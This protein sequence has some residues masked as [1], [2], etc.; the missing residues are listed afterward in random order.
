[1]WDK[2][3]TISP[4]I[5]AL[6]GGVVTAAAIID[7]REHR[8]P[9]YLTI[10]A[11]LI[12]FLYSFLNGWIGPASS[13]AGLLV[14]FSLLILPWI[15]GG[16]GMGDVKLLAAL[17]AWMG[18][19]YIL[20]IFAG[21]AMFASLMAIGIMIYTAITEGVGASKERYLATAGGTAN[22]S[23]V[24]KKMKRVVPFAVPIAMSS[25]IL[26]AWLLMRHSM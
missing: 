9:N 18:P 24:R 2:L 4:D 7:Y 3:P 15:L 22:T 14:G 12:G 11:A 8:I 17:G 6:V 21:A 13:L 25:W 10:P 23:G 20:F 5:V 19:I 26:L 1:M 16:G